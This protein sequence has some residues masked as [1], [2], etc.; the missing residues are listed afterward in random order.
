[1]LLSVE[2]LRDAALARLT[3]TEARSCVV[4]LAATPVTRDDALTFPRVTFPC[5]WDGYLAFADLD[6]AANWGH[7]CCYICI[8]G[9]TAEAHRIDAEFPPFGPRQD[10]PQQHW[11]V[12]YRAPGV[13]SAFVAAPEH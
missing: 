11:Q 3:A 12:I 4:Y 1:M 5:P 10:R 7:R 6:P 8:N 2:R 13:P 9:E